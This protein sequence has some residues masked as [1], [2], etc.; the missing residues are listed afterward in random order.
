MLGSDMFE[1][2][3]GVVNRKCCD[4]RSSGVSRNLPGMHAYS[5]DLQIVLTVQGDS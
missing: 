5:A 1:P 4:L 3:F 2:A